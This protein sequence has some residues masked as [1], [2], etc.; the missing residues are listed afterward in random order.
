MH[1]DDETHGP[2]LGSAGRD[3]EWRAALAVEPWWL[4]P[5]LLMA[6]LRVLGSENG[7]KVGLGAFWRNGCAV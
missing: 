4:R 1:R 6:V 2:H 7:F 3:G 5:C